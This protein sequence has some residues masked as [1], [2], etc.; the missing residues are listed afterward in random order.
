MDSVFNLDKAK[1]I[2]DSGVGKAE[3]MLKDNDQINQLLA[4]INQKLEQYPQLAETVKDVPTMI[5]MVKCYIT[6]D[7]TVVSPKVVASLISA[8]L[9]LVSRKDLIPDN[10]PILGLLDDIAVIG[11]AVKFSAPELKAFE[12]WRSAKNAAAA[13]ETTA[14]PVTEA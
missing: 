7:Y 11:L 10:V 12:E 8:F 2:L 6:K 4:Q 5:D 9:Y 13:V 3:E 14:E 1:E